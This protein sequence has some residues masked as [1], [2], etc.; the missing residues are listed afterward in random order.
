MTL[1]SPRRYSMSFVRRWQQCARL[2]HLERQANTAGRDAAVGSAFHAVA[3]AV[4]LACVMKGDTRPV[5]AEAE[6]IA[7]NVLAT[8][9]HALP[10]DDH[11]EVM[12][13]VRRWAPTVEFHPGE[14][15]EVLYEHML[16]GQP[17]SAKIDRL[18]VV[19]DR[20]IVKDLK[21]GWGKPADSNEPT[22]Q[23]DVYAWHVLQAHP[24]VEVVEYVEDWVRFGIQGQPFEYW[25]D[26]IHRVEDWLSGRVRAIH[27]AYT[28]DSLPVSPGHHCSQCPD[29]IG[30]PLPDWAKQEARVR[31]QADALEQLEALLVEEKRIAK[32]KKLIH[33]YLES[34]GERAVQVDGAEIGWGN[35]GSRLDDKAVKTAG[36]DLA[37]FRKPTL[38]S[39]GRRKSLK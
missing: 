28:K 25:R 39:F 4:G 29:P 16:D 24:D 21:S 2:A 33:G 10:P 31:T 38:P 37:P 9:E 20:A 23:G 15:F 35:P 1:E 27:A 19:G 30:C 3:A 12:S 22:L 14:Q 17:L 32:R 8:P 26:H 7:L 36:I 5:P 6:R 11:D 13:L 34:T 18:V